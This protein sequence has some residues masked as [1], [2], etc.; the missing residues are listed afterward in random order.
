MSHFY[1][2]III[3]AG[4]AGL[5]AAIY[6]ARNEKSALVMESAGVGGQISLSPLGENY[7]GFE[8]I[9]G[10]EFSDKLYEQALALGVELVLEEAEKIETAPDGSKVVYSEGG[11][12]KRT[13]RKLIIA[14][15]QKHRKLGL[16]NEEKLTGRGVSYCAVC[17]GPFFKKKTVAV[18]GGGSSALQ[19]ARLL[20]GLCEKVYL[21]HRREQFRGEQLLAGQLADL[22]NVEFVLNSTVQGLEGEDKLTALTVVR[23]DTGAQTRL[24]VDGLFVYIGQ[25]PNTEICKGVVQ[26]DDYGY[27][28][29][30]EDCRTSVPGIFAAGDCRTKSIRQLTTAAADGTVCALAD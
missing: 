9:S 1:D 18:V 30:A 11:A 7:P 19:S 20:A 17:D 8:K 13:C 4:T 2:T 3:G 6:T 10:A 12:V 5:T 21:I 22:A 14:T 23:T 28:V 15:G 16:A 26:I 27:I 25:L 29:A 24:P